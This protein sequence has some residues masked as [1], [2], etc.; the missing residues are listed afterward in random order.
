MSLTLNTLADQNSIARYSF[1]LA[2]DTNVVFNSLAGDGNLTWTLSGPNGYSLTRN[3]YYSGGYE[4]GGTNPVMALKAG[5][6]TLTLQASGSE[7]KDSDGNGIAANSVLSG[8]WTRRPGR[9][10]THPLVQ[11]R[12]YGRLHNHDQSS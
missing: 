5:A 4:L 3:F 6:Y 7:I 2:A 8:R 11:S 1:T 10:R 12:Q 9:P